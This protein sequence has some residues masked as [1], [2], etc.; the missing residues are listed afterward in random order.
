MSDSHKIYSLVLLV[1]CFMAP[2]EA[3]ILGQLIRKEKLKPLLWI[4]V[5]SVQLIIV[6]LAYVSRSNGYEIMQVNGIDKVHVEA[7]IA[8]AEMFIALSIATGALSIMV[9]FLHTKLR[10]PVTLVA[11]V[12]MLIQSTMCFKLKNSGHEV[13]S[14]YQQPSS[15]PQASVPEAVEIYDDND[16]GKTESE[17]FED[18]QEPED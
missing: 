1:L 8:L 4:S 14:H 16:Y 17:E 10:Y 13:F 12:M 15:V 3:I 18:S 11:T 6:V 9:L 7:H 5:V 2:P